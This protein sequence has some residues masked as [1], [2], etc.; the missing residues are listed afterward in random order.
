MAE[1][2]VGELLEE[3]EV[4]LRLAVVAG[5]K[6]LNRKITVSD[7]DRP[8]VTL[9]G[10]YEHFRSE[11]IQIIGMGEYTYLKMLSKEQREETLKK[12]FSFYIPCVIVTRN[13]APLEEL[14][15]YANETNTPLLSTALNTGEF[16]TQLKSYLDDK[17]APTTI[18]H[19]VLVDVYRLGVLI[20]GE[21]GIGK[22]ECAIELVRR[23]HFLVADDVVEIKCK[24]GNVLIGYSKNVVRYLMELRGLGIIDVRSLF[25]IS[26]ILNSTTIEL[27]IQLAEWEKINEI[28]R[29]GMEERTITILGVNV[30]E[31]LLPVAPGRNLAVLV[32]IA[33]L[34]QQLKKAGYNVV[35]ELNY[36]LLQMLKKDDKS[37]L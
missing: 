32:E 17:L 29:S 5:H 14:V 28:D 15:K 9:A 23:G 3:K 30:P 27:V 25:G 36:K 4:I 10:I 19:G 18:L 6:G 35:R 8:G 21:S 13:L 11:R 31:I 37:A 2:T 22:S 12:F 26:S 33:A 24:P 34:N 1:I 20:M 16:I 7:I